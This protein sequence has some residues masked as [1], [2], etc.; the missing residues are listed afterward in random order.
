MPM[1]AGITLTGVKWIQRTQGSYTADNN[2]KVGLYSYSGGTLTLV[3]SCADDGNLWKGASGSVQSKAFSSTYVTLTN[4]Q[5][6][7]AFIYNNS[8]QVTAPQISMSTPNTGSVLTYQLD[9]TNSAK[10]VSTKTATTDLAATQ[11]MSGTLANL[12][13]IPMMF[14]Y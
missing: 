2:N 4:T 13:A 12:S 8:A 1:P 5:Y 7:V 3:A 9:F 11:A 14:L 10:L 6:F